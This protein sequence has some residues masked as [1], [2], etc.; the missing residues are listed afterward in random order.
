MVCHAASHCA[1]SCCGLL[2]C[3]S[4][5]FSTLLKMIACQSSAESF[6]FCSKQDHRARCLGSDRAV[7]KGWVGLERARF[8]SFS[9]CEVQLP[10]RTT[11]TALGCLVEPAFS[12]VGASNFKGHLWS[13][14]R[15][16]GSA[17]NEHQQGHKDSA[18]LPAWVFMQTF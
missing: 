18:Q 11:R 17:W 4:G 16:L 12:T 9:T 5:L 6:L 10:A 13:K 14:A 1:N 8:T 15:G 3:C 2:S 7:S